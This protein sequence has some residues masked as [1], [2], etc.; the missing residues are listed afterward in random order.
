MNL[1]KI[2]FSFI[3]MLFIVNTTYS[4]NNTPNIEVEKKHLSQLEEGK[5]II[6]QYY[7]KPISFYNKNT[8]VLNGTSKGEFIEIEIQGTIK[9]FQYI[10]IEMDS[11][12]DL[13][14]S[15]T[16]SAF[17]QLSDQR[18]IINTSIPEGIPA[19][20]IKWKSLSN[21]QYEFII[22]ENGDSK[23]QIEFILD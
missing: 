11:T 21:Q 15:K 18:I 8:I 23:K 9:D 22:A 13:H 16:L 20:K 12:G 5:I 6:K 17:K 7:K 1:K 3:V 2:I 4:Q 10:K 14:E 19:E